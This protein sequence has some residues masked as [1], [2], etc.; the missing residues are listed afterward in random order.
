MSLPM[1]YATASTASADCAAVAPVWART[2][3]RSAPNRGSKNARLAE[4][5]AWPPPRNES[6]CAAVWSETSNASPEPAASREIAG[7][8]ADGAAPP[9]SA[10]AIRSAS[11]S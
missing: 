5:S 6:I 7:G 4:E 2:W 3:P 10:A 8:A 11:C 9:V 1:V